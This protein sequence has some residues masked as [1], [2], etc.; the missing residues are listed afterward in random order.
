M[1]KNNQA[2]LTSEEESRYVELQNMALDAARS[3]QTSTL[4]PM[5]R[6]G[7][8]VNLSDHKGN[9]LIMLASYHDHP[10]TVECLAYYQANVDQRNDRGQTPLAGVAFKGH[11]DCAR[12]LVHYGANAEAPQGHGQTPVSFA[13]MFG[14]KEMLSFLQS[15]GTKRPLKN[16][17]LRLCVMMTRIVRRAVGRVIESRNQRRLR[18]A[19]YH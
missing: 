18:W 16:G 5:L 4:E 9:S 12:I 19:V 6:S 7:M 8:P 17:L 10:E 2:Q 13:A 15:V 11:M 14:R 3:G 1:K